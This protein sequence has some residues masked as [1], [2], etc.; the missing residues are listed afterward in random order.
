[1]TKNSS[2]TKTRR[3]EEVDQAGANEAM[4]VLTHLKLTGLKL[5]YRLNFGEELMKNGIPR[6]LNS[7]VSAF[8]AACCG[9]LASEY[10]YKFFLENRDSPELAPGELQ[11]NR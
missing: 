9:G 11:W 1:M 4:Q 2:H 10:D 7:G 6:I 3:H 5:G 8:P